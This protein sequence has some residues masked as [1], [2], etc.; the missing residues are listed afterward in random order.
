MLEV[1]VAMIVFNRPELTRRTFESVR[2]AQPKKLCIISDGPRAD[3]S[4]EASLVAQSRAIAENC[5]WPCEIDR[6]YSDTNLGCGRRVS[7]G[8]TEVFAKHE[9]AIIIED[10]CLVNDSFFQYCSE[11]LE[12]Y[13]DDERV[14]AISGDNFHNGQRFGEASYFFSKYPHCWGWATWRRAWARYATAL[15]SWPQYRDT[16][17]MAAMCSS[18]AEQDYW[19]RTFDRVY[20]GQIDTWDFTWVL[21]CWMHN[22]LTALPN[23]NLVSNIG[24]GEG[25]THCSEASP[26]AELPTEEI[27]QIEHPTRVTRSYLADQRT[28]RVMFSRGKL[29]ARHLG[30]LARRWATSRAA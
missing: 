24:F 10:D 28:D 11:L 23:V 17:D 8:I 9:R 2:R 3:R 20:A 15:P 4:G 22:G 16:Q 7:S 27:S 19:T 26:W 14:M 13:A 25:A 18:I 1:P 30:Q 5:D 6:F 21:A 12:Y 29:K